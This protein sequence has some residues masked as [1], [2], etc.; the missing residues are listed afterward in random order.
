[1]KRA[2]L[3]R[4]AALLCLT[5]ASAAAPGGNLVEA[6]SDECDSL[7]PIWVAGLRGMPEVRTVQN[8]VLSIRSVDN[9][10]D[11]YPSAEDMTTTYADQIGRGLPAAEAPS[12]IA[13]IWLPPFN[14]WPVGVNAA[15]FREWF[16]VRVTAYDADL[17]LSNGYYFP[18]IYLATDD[19]GA[20]LIA[21][22]GD[23]YGPDITIGRVT[24]FGW[25]TIG[26]AFNAQGV[27]EYYAAPGRV[28]L[29]SADLLHV[30]PHSADPAANR[31]IDQ[32]IGNFIALRMTY[33]S[34]GQLSTD[35]QMDNFRVYLRTPPVLPL[36]TPA[37]GGGRVQIKI[38]S[39]ARGSSL[40]P[41]SDLSRGF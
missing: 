40:G 39:G 1:M 27:T 37:F 9:G 26:L 13:Q 2:G 31:S 15:G 4:L 21:R 7:N 20:C 11:D 35:W 29:T 28:S 25:W 17:P 6:L 10:D 30:T 22:V 38:G 14:E 36:L 12:V 19:A 32:L 3:S 24:T 16:G 23:G 34:T 5:S 41:K 18:G 33:P 8:G